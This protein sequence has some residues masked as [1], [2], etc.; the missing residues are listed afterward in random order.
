MNTIND[1]LNKYTLTLVMDHES[2]LIDPKGIEVF[3]PIIGQKETIKKLRFFVG[4]H[5]TKTPCPTL[6]FTGS[7][8]LG[9]TFMAKK[10]AD[11]LGR[12]LI[13]V[14][15]GA[16]ETIDD[17][18]EGVLINRVS[19]FTP[20]TILLDEAHEISPD[21]TTNLLTLLNP[22]STNINKLAY[23]NWNVEYDFSKLN[24]ILATTDAHKIFRPLL[25]RCVEIYFSL[26]SHEELYAILT[27]YLPG[28]SICCNPDEIAYACR[29]RARDA[30]LLSQNIS[31][32]CVMNKTSIFGNK[33]WDNVKE[34]FGLHPCGL[35]TQEVELLKIVAEE[36]PISLTNLSVKMGLNTSN[37]ESEI[38]IRPRELGFIDN[39]ARGRIL[40]EK[41][42]EYLRKAI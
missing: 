17:F 35:K 18:I 10:V 4:S 41:G 20:K 5:S 7:Q 19:G 16:M 22:T 30:Y 15:S 25:N 27:N 6:L 3:D 38:E 39:A 23:K 24:V 14:N 28:I 31:R 11:A 2:R 34:I 29:G 13:E 8:G 12:E 36:G 40:T 26:Y 1:Q 21:I 32:Y 42:R 9:K 33:A 37:V